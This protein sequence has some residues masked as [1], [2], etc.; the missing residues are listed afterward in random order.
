MKFSSVATA[1]ARASLCS[2]A[3]AACSIRSGSFRSPNSFIMRSSVR[4]SISSPTFFAA[5]RARSSSSPLL[6][7]NSSATRSAGIP[8]FAIMP[9]LPYPSLA[10][11]SPR[12]AF[13]SARL[14]L[15]TFSAETRSPFS[16]VVIPYFRKSIALKIGSAR[17]CS[18]TSSRTAL[19]VAAFFFASSFRNL[20]FMLPTHWKSRML[21]AVS[22]LTASR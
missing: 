12:T 15:P 19:R 8:S 17:T 2:A 18:S 22:S 6:N 11:S 16:D 5:A 14:S 1:R 10:A 3:F 13:A 4:A 7:P 9:Y 21:R 20:L